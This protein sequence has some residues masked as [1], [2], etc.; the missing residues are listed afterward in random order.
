MLMN[1]SSLGGNI[2]M[3]GVQGH[4][5]SSSFGD[6]KNPINAQISHSSTWSIND[7]Y[8]KLILNMKSRDC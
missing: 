2:E 5:F 8:F 4:Q 1:V 7:I 6:K 3:S